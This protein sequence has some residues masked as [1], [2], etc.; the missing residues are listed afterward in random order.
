MSFEKSP[1]NQMVVLLVMNTSKKKTESYPSNTI[2]PGGYE[3][4]Y[5]KVGRLI[6]QS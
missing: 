3:N 2:F 6:S 1:Q 4:L 5:E